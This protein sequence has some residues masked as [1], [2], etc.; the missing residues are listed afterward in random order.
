MCKRP[1]SAVHL[2]N[3]FNFVSLHLTEIIAE[4]YH[5]EMEDITTFLFSVAEA[6]QCFLGILTRENRLEMLQKCIDECDEKNLSIAILPLVRTAAKYNCVEILHYFSQ[7]WDIDFSEK[8][9]KEHIY[10]CANKHQSIELLNFI[11]QKSP[12]RKS[13][14]SEMNLNLHT[15]LTTKNTNSDF[16]RQFKKLIL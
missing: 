12:L 16:M 8:S 7:L 14:L 10:F 2:Y 4:N 11:Y 5:I 6:R 3:E 13:E 1:F 15:F 9:L